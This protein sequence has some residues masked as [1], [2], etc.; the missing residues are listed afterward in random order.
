[1]VLAVVVGIASMFVGKRQSGTKPIP[2]MFSTGIV[3]VLGSWFLFDST[4]VPLRIVRITAERDCSAKVSDG[5]VNSACET[6][7]KLA[8]H[9][10]QAK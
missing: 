4:E 9:F 8:Q 1:M 10:G 2:G 6:S 3:L 7:S 5:Y